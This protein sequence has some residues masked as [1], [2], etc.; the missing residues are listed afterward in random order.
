MNPIVLITD[1]TMQELT[2]HGTSEYPVMISC[3]LTYTPSMGVIPWHWHSSFELTYIES[4]HFDFSVSTDT[5]VLNPGEAILINS[6]VLHQIKPFHQE[7]TVYFS[8]VF[9]SELISDSV[10]SLIAAKYLIPFMHNTD[11]PF[12]IFHPQVAWESKSLLQIRQLNQAAE[13]DSF[14]RE[15]QIQHQLQALF[16]TLFEQLPHACTETS[17]SANDDSYQ[18]MK[19]MV[20]LKEHYTETIT[21]S[22]MAAAASISKSSCN[23]LFHKTLKMTPFEYLLMLRID[24]SKRLLDHGTQSVTEIGYSCGFHDISYYCK[25]FRRYSGVSPQEYRSKK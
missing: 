8:Y 7:D 18:I 24:Q 4:G 5:F 1:H 6:K 10:Q 16:I 15:F 3:G 21:L 17:L 20:Y 25:A 11:F 13:S 22:D 19:I 14:V 9:S 23:R 2:E 12:Q